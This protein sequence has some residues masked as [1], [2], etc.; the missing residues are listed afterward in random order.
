MSNYIRVDTAG[1]LSWLRAKN[2]P[3]IDIS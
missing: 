2:T 3:L 1:A